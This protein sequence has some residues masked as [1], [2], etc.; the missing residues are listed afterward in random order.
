MV[1]FVFK[2]RQGSRFLH[3]MIGTLT[4]VVTPA[5]ARRSQQPISIG[6]DWPDSRRFRSRGCGRRRIA[7]RLLRV[8]TPS[9]NDARLALGRRSKSSTGTGAQMRSRGLLLRSIWLLVAMASVSTAVAAPHPVS[10]VDAWLV[11]G[12]GELELRLIT[13]LDDVIRHQQPATSTAGLI[14]GPEFQQAVTSHGQWLKEHVRIYDQD[15]E[16][17]LFRVVA[18]PDQEVL[19]SPVDAEGDAGIRLTWTLQSSLEQELTALTF[20]PLL[21]HE[22]LTFRPELRLHIKDGARNR[23][24]DATVFD[25]TSHTVVLAGSGRAAEDSPTAVFGAD[26]VNRLNLS[27]VAAGPTLLVE[28]NAS[29]ILLMDPSQE[30]GKS[31]AGSSD[32]WDLEAIAEQSR[33]LA[34]QFRSSAFLQLPSGRRLD[35]DSVNSRFGLIAD[36]Q[37]DITA[38]LA[39]STLSPAVVAASVQLEFPFD[40][41]QKDLKF[42]WTG[43]PELLTDVSVT[44]LTPRG[45]ESEAVLVD[46]GQLSVPLARLQNTLLSLTV[47]SG[48]P[49]G[50]MPWTNRSG[51]PAFRAVL[52]AVVL[53]V[54]AAIGAF[55]WRRRVP[56]VAGGSLVLAAVGLLLSLDRQ[57]QRIVDCPASAEIVKQLLDD[58]VKIASLPVTE[59]SA[60]ALLNIMSPELA[61][62]VFLRLHQSLAQVETEDQGFVLTL[63]ETE[64]TVRSCSAGEDEE[65]SIIVEGDWLLQGRVFHWGHLHDRAV[66]CSGSLQAVCPEDRWLLKSVTLTEVQSLAVALE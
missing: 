4:L 66:L 9:A 53:F 57:E 50:E 41:N 18:V 17:I 56:I 27:L 48:L 42:I 39:Q 10:H 55:F 11:V 44:M 37:Q 63:R 54:L 46:A 40:L 31:G 38:E 6:D 60:D 28:I 24:I 32:G 49:A 19:P 7:Q 51:W 21:S 1:C 33:M 62:S 20:F 5:D 30:S 36:P 65:R 59:E 2:E 45:A 52:G 61:E 16:R 47:P 34:D 22:S 58:A 29:V 3:F 13:F 35:P 25:A 43:V 26:D 23:R 14:D 64:F 12:Q 8:E 15:G